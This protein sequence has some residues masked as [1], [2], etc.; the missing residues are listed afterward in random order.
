MRK[1]V[2]KLVPEKCPFF[3]IEED[4]AS[5]IITQAHFDRTQADGINFSSLFIS[6]SLSHSL[7][8]IGVIQKL[9]EGGLSEVISFFHDDILFAVDLYDDGVLFDDKERVGVLLFFEKDLIFLQFEELCAIDEK[10]SLFICEI[11][12]E[13]YAI[14]HGIDV[15]FIILHPLLD[16]R[17]HL[18]FLY[19]VYNYFGSD[20]PY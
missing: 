9:K 11:V 7:A 6:N 2:K 3:L 20:D 18:L 13:M 10:F 12:E 1:G 15:F 8:F 4:D 5:Y 16:Y 14:E 19:R 17:H